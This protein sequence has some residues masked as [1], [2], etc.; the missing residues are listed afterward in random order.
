MG[1]LRAGAGRAIITPPTGLF[2]MGYIAREHKAV[3][4]HD[5]LAATA[6]VLDDGGTK[7][8]IVTCD[9]IFLHPAIVARI[10]S[11]AYLRTGISPDHHMLCCSHTHSGPVMFADETSP[12][13]QRAYLEDLVVLIVEAVE[14]A[15]HNL[16]DAVWG[17]ARGL[18]SIGMN[19]RQHM[20]NGRIALG[21]NP[22]GPVDPSVQVLRVDTADGGPLALLV[23]HACHAV[24]LSHNSYAI[25][26]DWP[27]VMRRKVETTLALS[28][29]LPVRCAFV[30]GAGADINPLGGPQDTF[31]SAERLGT[32]IAEEVLAL[33]DSVEIEDLRCEVT[34]E[35]TRTEISLPL[36]GPVA[37]D[38]QRVP[39]FA[40]L[41]SGIMHMPWEE[42]KAQLKQ[43]FP[44][45]AHVEERD[46]VWHA[47]AELQAFRLGDVVLVGVAAEPFTEI[48]LQVKDRSPA[49]LTLFAGYTNG[50]I[51][52]L[53]PPQ[54]YEEGGYEVRD[55][56]IYYRLPAPLAP[57]CAGLVIDGLLKLIEGLGVD[58]QGRSRSLDKD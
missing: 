29:H 8:A 51:S 55:A 43:R 3:S 11:L 4:V 14:E 2:M 16:Q 34:L 27:G 50:S 42:A 28:G 26:A 15:N 6:L 44:W 52:Y 9:L 47:T 1:R 40:E 46:G 53:A 25:S 36:L 38:G 56:Y 12:E 17:V 45:E 35:A 10:R 18:A 13:D 57:A 33:C 58:S 7:L 24:C 23:N 5:D 21:E 22:Q 54:A 37:P 32:E 39:P 49:A 41:A 30:Q 48:G 19:R 20:A 31:D